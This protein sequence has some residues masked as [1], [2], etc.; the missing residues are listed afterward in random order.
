MW[1][2]LLFC[3]FRRRRREGVFLVLV[4][5]GWGREEKSRRK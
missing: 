4:W 3:C 1:M 5:V 2:R